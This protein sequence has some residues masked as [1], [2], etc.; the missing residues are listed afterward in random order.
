M[1]VSWRQN[2]RSQPIGPSRGWVIVSSGPEG[3]GVAE[4]T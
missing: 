3:G 2:Q 4:S 1:L